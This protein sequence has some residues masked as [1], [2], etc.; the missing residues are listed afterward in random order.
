MPPS[1]PLVPVVAPA[2]VAPVPPALDVLALVPIIP[3][4]PDAV[5]GPSV[6]ELPVVVVVESPP[7]GPVAATV[8]GGAPVA[9][10][11]ALPAVC[12]LLV[13][14][15]PPVASLHAPVAPIKARNKLL[16]DGRSM[17]I[18]CAPRRQ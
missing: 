10:V 1:A 18:R 14:S 2:V 11:V 9:L 8:E 3:E 12:E 13:G 6:L 15:A 5:D 16:H 17:M 7:A 4:A